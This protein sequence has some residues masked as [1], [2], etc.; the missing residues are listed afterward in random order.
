MKNFTVIKLRFRTDNIKCDKF[1]QRPTVMKI[2]KNRLQPVWQV[3]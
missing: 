3:S 1:Y 2:S